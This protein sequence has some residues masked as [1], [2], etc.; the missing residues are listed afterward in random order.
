M[1]TSS[2]TRAAFRAATRTGQFLAAHG[3]ITWSWALR[4]GSF[5]AFL[6][7]IIGIAGQI[8]TISAAS[9]IV[10]ASLEPTFWQRALGVSITSLAYAATGAVVGLLSAPWMRSR[11]GRALAATT[12][13]VV[14]T[15]LVS[16]SVMSTVVRVLS[17]THLTM[18]A[19]SFCVSSSD[20]FLRS[21]VD[22]H[23][24][25]L[26]GAICVVLLVALMLAIRVA[27]LI[28]APGAPRFRAVTVMVA[29]LLSSLGASVGSARRAFDPRVFGSTPELAFARSLRHSSGLRDVA[30]AA[31]QDAVE[32]PAL[33]QARLEE[34]AWQ[35]ELEESP[36]P[37]PNV[38]ILVLESVSYR[39]LGYEGYR[40]GVTPN[41]DALAKGGV[42]A[43]RAWATATHSNY[44]QMA[45]LSS[46]FPR[47]RHH[48]DMY[49]VLNYPRLL[50]H[51]LFHK[52]GYATAT[53]SSQD[54]NWQGMRRFQNTG[55]PTYFWHAPDHPG[56]HLDIGSEL[57]VPDE[58]TVSHV[59]RWL[60]RHKGTP[61]ALY[62]NLQATHFPYRLPDHAPRTF[63]PDEPTPATF[64]YLRYPESE[65]ERVINRYDNALAYVDR[66]IGRLRNHLLASGEYENTLWVVTSDHG[67]MFHQ[68]GMVTHGRSLFDAESRVPLIIHWPKGLK[69][70]DVWSPVSHLDVMPTVS[71]LIEVPAHPSYQ[72]RDFLGAPG[73][74]GVFMSIQGLRSVDGVVCHP[75]KFLYDSTGQRALLF[76]LERD[77]GEEKDLLL[78]QPRVAAALAS[79]LQA[80]LDAQVEYHQGDPRLSREVFQPRLGSCPGWL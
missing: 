54:E 34:K 52:L 36:G 79:L 32:Q 23:A 39:H 73:N 76:H 11:L 33:G 12:F 75:W 21:F 37:R 57:V 6:G 47:R 2:L 1:H 40:R 58:I 70:R 7:C 74:S 65:L 17:G 4:L 50:P 48:L 64:S 80:Q 67:E 18:G 24:W 30:I 10:D 60:D 25:S 71:R 66:Q 45:I 68:H 44:A 22:G 69:P 29:V 56:P 38:L 72:G 53:I 20:H 51:D 61:W 27:S 13:T 59:K 41:I 14:F 49:Q 19:L 63:K 16:A 78:E 28:C 8:V 3:S 42:R 55:T 43:R 62:V 9:P 35:K 31:G 46:L 5:G 15:L 26:R 77:P